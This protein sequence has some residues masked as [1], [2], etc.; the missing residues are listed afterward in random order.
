MANFINLV[1]LLFKVTINWRHLFP[2]PVSVSNR[3][4]HGIIV[5]VTYSFSLEE[6]SIL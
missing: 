2:R 6:Q 1:L 5:I 3:E 4:N